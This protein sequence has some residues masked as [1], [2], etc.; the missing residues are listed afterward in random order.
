MAAAA[1]AIAVSIDSRHLSEE[2]LL[3]PKEIDAKETYRTSTV[4]L[5]T[6]QTK[7]LF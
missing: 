7:M 4:L 3:L 6:P 2:H 5:Y 1:N